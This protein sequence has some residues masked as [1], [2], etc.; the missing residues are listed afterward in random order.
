MREPPGLQ[1][2]WILLE[3]GEYQQ[4][5][6]V[7]FLSGAEIPARTI[8]RVQIQTSKENAISLACRHSNTRPLLYS[9]TGPLNTDMAVNVTPAVAGVTADL[10][11]YYLNISPFNFI[12][13]MYNLI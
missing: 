8:A 6:V 13:R 12:A 7:C 11:G 4:L 9:S 3:L 1:C 10:R 5:T 2:M